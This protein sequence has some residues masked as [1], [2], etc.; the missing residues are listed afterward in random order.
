[1]VPRP[2]GR[3]LQNRILRG[4]LGPNTKREVTG[5]WRK[6]QRTNFVIFT[7]HMREV[8]VG[9]SYSTMGKNECVQT[10]VTVKVCS[11]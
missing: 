9:E 1:M 10:H 5:R 6:V 7:H 3:T 4:I 8:E 2:D 11:V